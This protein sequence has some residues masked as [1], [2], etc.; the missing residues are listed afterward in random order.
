[1]GAGRAGPKGMRGAEARRGPG[2]H[3]LPPTFLTPHTAPPQR[4]P[5]ADAVGRPPLGGPGA[6]MGGGASLMLECLGASPPYHGGHP[7]LTC[8]L[9]REPGRSHSRDTCAHRDRGPVGRAAPHAGPRPTNAAVRPQGC[10]TPRRHQ[11][12]H[13]S[14]VTSA[15]CGAHGV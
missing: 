13:M 11:A 8:G 6:G 3:T 10:I 9:T 12:L 15:P 14:N 5:G 1:M 2:P 7:R 4:C